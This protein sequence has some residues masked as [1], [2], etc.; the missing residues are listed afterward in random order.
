[1]PKNIKNKTTNTPLVLVILDGWGL[2]KETEGNAIAQAKTPVM[3][4]LYKQY[5]HTKINASEKEVGLSKNQPGNSEAGHMNIGAGRVVEQDSISISKSIN[6]GTFFKNPAFLQAA[7][8]VTKNKSDIHLIGL[9]SDKSSP[10]AD[11]DHILS[12]LSFFVNKT[13]RNIYLHLFTDGRDSPQFAAARILEKY[14]II[15]DRKRIKIATI[16]GR[17]YAMDRKKTWD[18]TE[19]AYKAMVLGQGIEVES[20][21]E[22]VNQAYNRGESDEFIQPTV[23]VKN[24][25]PIATIKDKD[26]VIFFNLRSDR[27][28]QLAKVFAQTNFEKKNKG[29]FKPKKKFKNLLFVALTDFGPD[30][31]N[32]LT[33]FPGIDI[34]ETLPFTLRDLRQLY[35]A[36][37]EKYA[38]VTYFFNGGYDHVIAGEDRVEIPSKDVDSYSTVPAMSTKEVNIHVRKV[39]KEDKYDFI[40]VNFA[41]PDMV[42]HTGDLVAGIKA[43][44]VVD[45]ELGKLVNTVLKK[46][47]TI[48]VTADHGNIEEM[49][50]LETKEIDTKHSINPVPLI[51]INHIKYKLRKNGKLADI[52]PTIL[53]IL[54]LPKPKL[55]Q[56]KSLIKSRV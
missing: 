20:A 37:T 56:A 19:T 6:N 1:M 50:N 13:D 10:H 51:V 21:S 54:D 30:L 33:A 9:L 41:S 28:R 32:I 52:A 49:I 2:W 47:G 22:A 45:T 15:F 18:R 39:I 53:D 29:A 16:M 36:E 27:A 8:Q 26:A 43:V 35:I 14:K 12:L 48:I 24:K 5:P 31:D 40:C 42:A 44:E 25:K 11:N 17:F 23:I 4:G 38:H 34:P 55:M 3:D 7:T 46:N